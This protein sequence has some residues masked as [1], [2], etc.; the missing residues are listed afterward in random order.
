MHCPTRNV[1]LV[2]FNTH[3]LSASPSSLVSRASASVTSAWAAAVAAS[4][5]VAAAAAGAPAASLAGAV[6]AVAAAVAPPATAAAAPPAT[7]SAATCASS[8]ASFSAR[9]RTWTKAEPL[10]SAAALTCV[11]QCGM[12]VVWNGDTKSVVLALAA[13]AEGTYRN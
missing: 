5:G 3:T 13:Q 12:C 9:L 11:R 8:A 10:C 4:V 7:A 2:L 6:S 1:F